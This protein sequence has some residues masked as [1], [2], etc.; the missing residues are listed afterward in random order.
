MNKQNVVCLYNE[1]LFGNSKEWN[2]GIDCNMNETQ[3][4][5]D[6]QR[7][8]FHFSKYP[9]RQVYKDGSEPE[10][11]WGWDGAETDCERAMGNLGGGVL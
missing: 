8:Y 6:R 11:P 2:T 1:I 4:H 5:Y 9:K 10:V 7:L 3:N